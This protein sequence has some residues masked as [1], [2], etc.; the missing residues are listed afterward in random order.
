MQFKGKLM[1]QTWENGKNPNFGPDFGL[2]GPNLGPPN[3][4]VGF[5][6]TSSYTLF[7]AIILCNL[8]EN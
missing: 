1:N 7:Q 4:F 8:K 5:T 2:F 6:S 3:L